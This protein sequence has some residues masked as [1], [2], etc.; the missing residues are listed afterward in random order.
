MSILLAL[1]LA[2]AGTA[3]WT[4]R[5]RQHSENGRA[6]A[7]G[8]D[9][10]RPQSGNGRAAA[11][12]TASGRDRRREQSRK[13]R[14]AAAAAAAAAAVCIATGVGDTL[15]GAAA[16]VLSI[17]T[18]G[19][20]SSA[21]FI[22]VMMTG[23][24]P[25][26]SVARRALLPVRGELSIL[27]SILALGHSAGYLFRYLPRMVTSAGDM[28][29]AVLA[30]VLCGSAK[31]L[32]MLPLFITSFPA[33]RR[34]MKA[35]AWK[36]L[37]RLAYVFYA[38]LYV[39]AVLLNGN[40]V[41]HG[42]ADAL[43]A[44]CVYSVI[45]AVYAV[46][47]IRRALSKGDR[48]PSGARR[49]VV[50]TVSAA[51]LLAVFFAAGEQAGT[52]KAEKAQKAQ[53]STGAAEQAEAAGSSE[54]SAAGT[55]DANGVE[56]AGA[57]AGSDSIAT[58]ADGTYR[59]SGSGYNGRLKVAVTVE[60]GVITELKLLASVDDKPYITKAT[61]D[62]F[63]KVLEAQSTDVDTTSGATPSAEG[64]LEAIGAAIE[65]ASAAGAAEEQSLKEYEESD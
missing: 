60:G 9:R 16:W 55:G 22:E 62:I 34:K 7:P 49:A 41:R 36:K 38:L 23:A 18:G 47:R 54:N 11:P 13:L 4:G 2:A 12:G 45:F 19:T 31:F 35:S 32:L 64:L 56:N 25:D 51:A 10:S 14:V 44:I 48:D 3:L 63:A 15:P 42:H 52:W 37:Q 65:E 53:E 50:T 21:L 46:L 17:F 27:A 58:L 43:A 26:K 20:L 28:E 24:L 6:A 30:G 33:V 1:L 8:S 40:K 59:T 39:H 61:D 57:A 5:R 29:S